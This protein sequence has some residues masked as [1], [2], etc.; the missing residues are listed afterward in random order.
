MSGPETEAGQVRSTDGSARGEVLVER[1][2]GGVAVVTLDAPD[3]RNA[4]TLSMSA[5][6]AAAVDALVADPAVRSLV[7]TGTPPAFCAGA[8]LS[9]LRRADEDGLHRIYAAFLT[10][11]DCPLPTIAAVNGPAVGAGLNL[12]LACDLRLV[13]Y[14]ARLE[15]RFLRL[16]IHPGGGN[17]W[18]L[19]QLGGPQTAA[20]MTLFG[21]V[22]SGEECVRAGL[23]WRNVSAD[24]LVEESVELASRLGA[25]P[26]ELTRRAKETLRR[27]PSL[28][29]AETLEVELAHQL[30]SLEQARTETE[31]SGPRRQD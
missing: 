2:D 10:V 12:A 13:T 16:G 3:R 26:P 24:R 29:H 21:E 17:S 22:L 6:V 25:Y 19:R 23:A 1:R 18:L 28:S 30:W 4:L 31:P 15:T 9:A 27:V 5:E 7:V 11:L 8:D 20:A 14:A